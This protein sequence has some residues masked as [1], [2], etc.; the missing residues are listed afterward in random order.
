MFRKTLLFILLVWTLTSA[1]GDPFF[2]EDKAKHFLL[3]ACMAGFI[4]YGVT[5]NSRQGPDRAITAACG[6]TL[7]MGLLKEVHDARTPGNHFCLKDLFWDMAGI[8]AGALN[9]RSMPAR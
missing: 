9:A 3:S 1:A 5:L 6:I 2:G 7:S 4:T 8:T